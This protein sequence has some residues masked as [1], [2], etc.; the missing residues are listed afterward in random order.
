MIEGK[1]VY[2]LAPMETWSH[3]QRRQRLQELKKGNGGF[4]ST[5]TKTLC[6]RSPREGWWW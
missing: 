5:G 1:A 3:R 4:M 6:R 2:E